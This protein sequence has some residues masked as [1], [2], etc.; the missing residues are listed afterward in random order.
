MIDVVIVDI[1]L[2]LFFHLDA[3]GTD[4]QGFYIE[5]GL[6]HF[7]NVAALSIHYYH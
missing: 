7:L 1:F 4:R 3:R 5:I 6:T 2:R